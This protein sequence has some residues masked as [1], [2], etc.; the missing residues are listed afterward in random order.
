MV[1][2]PIVETF[3]HR[4]MGELVAGLFPTTQ[5]ADVPA[6]V[7]LTY[8][9]RDELVVTEVEYALALRRLRGSVKTPEQDR[10]WALTV[11]TG[12]T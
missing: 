2:S 6:Y 9:C 5:T 3:D 4:F 10:V 12:D 8:E 7:A 11:D 1:D